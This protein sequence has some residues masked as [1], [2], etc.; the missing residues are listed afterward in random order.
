[1][2]NVSFLIISV[3]P[4]IP[5]L[6][7]CDMTPAFS[8]ALL[9]AL[10]WGSVLAPQLCSCESLHPILQHHSKHWFPRR[11]QPCR[12]GRFTAVTSRLHTAFFQEEKRCY[13]EASARGKVVSVSHHAGETAG[14]SPAVVWPPAFNCRDH[15]RLDHHP[16]FSSHFHSV[17]VDS[18]DGR[19]SS[20]VK[21]KSMNV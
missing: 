11:L 14:G 10:P 4:R 6:N 17:T 2:K 3:T 20:S 18:A 16:N 15:A 7:H 12:S 9:A 19:S 8:W 21:G 13:G 5:K 1:M